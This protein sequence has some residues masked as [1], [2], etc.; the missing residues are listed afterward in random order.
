MSEG[1]PKVFRGVGASPGVAIGRVFLLDR[2]EVRVPRFHLEP[3]QTEAEIARLRAAIDASVAQLDAIRSRCTG[4]GVEHQGI[5]EAHSMMMRDRMMREE[6]EGLITDEN[7]NAEW[8]VTRVIGRIRGLFDQLTDA[9]LK[10]RRGDIDFTGERI[11]RNLVGQH[12]DISDLAALGDDAI[13]VARDLSPVDTALLTRHTVHAFVTEMG[14]KTSHTSIIARS[15]E[16]PAVVGAKGIF[17]AAGSGDVIVVDGLDGTVML[18]P[19]RTQLERGRR[20]AE[21]FHRTTLELLEA[22]AL[23][24]CTQDGRRVQVAGNIELPSEVPSVLGRGGEGIGLYRTE[25]M[26][27]GRRDL[28]TEE[29]HYLTY[30]QVFDHVGDRPVTVRTLD[31]GGDKMMGPLHFDTEAN[32][33]LG[34]RAIR[35]CLEHRAIFEPQIAGLLRA[36]LHGDLRIMLPMISGVEEFLTAKAVIQ[37]VADKLHKAGIPHQADLPVGMMVEVPSAA[38]CA[39]ALAQHAAFFSIGTNDLMQYLLAIDRTNE[40]VAHLYRPLHPAM[41]RVLKMIVDAG[42]QANIKVSVC[43]EMAG[44]S[45]FT[46]ILLGLGVHQLSMNM[47]SIPKIKRLVREMKQAE[48]ESLLAQALGCA[49]V[50]ETEAMVRHFMLKHMLT[51]GTL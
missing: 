11:I 39:E 25:Y 1:R 7:L 2:G 3:E 4:E 14:G 22:K 33:A 30:R 40:R 23:P 6:I 48:C 47:G 42:K 17:D 28:P 37:D 49:Q 51:L 32:P 44:D 21:N 8:A 41:L 10:E 35:Y 38:L 26:F 24:A 31:L 12:A 20:R 5:L 36:G 9:Y 45:D 15:L 19:S 34:L 18:R 13:V 16:V 27:L 50:R 43:G 46:P 29:E